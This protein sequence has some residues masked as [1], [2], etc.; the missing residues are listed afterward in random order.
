M[1]G[2]VRQ[3]GKNILASWASLAVRV[4]LVFLV[5]PFIIHTL[6]N[7][8]YGVWVLVVSIINYM[9][10]LDLGL[11]Q[12]LIRFISKFLGLGDY[13]KINSILNTAFIVYSMVGFIVIA[14][15]FILSFFAL[16]WFNIPEEHLSQGRTVLIIV[17]INTALNFILLCWGNS[18]GGFHRFD[19][20][21]AALIFEDIFRTVAI[22][23]LLKKGFGLVAFALA[24]L[25]FSQLRLVIGGGFLKVLFPRV[26]LDFRAVR[27]ET[28][29][30]LFEYGLISFLISIA[31]LLIANT[32]NVIIG[33]FLD[34]S[35]VTKFAIAAGFIV[36]L[37]SLVHA[38]SFPLRPVVS[39]YETLDKKENIIFIYTR[40]TKFLYF[41]TFAVAGIT[42][43]FADNFIY[44]WLG[45]GYSE[46]AAVLRILILPA[47]VFLPQ[48]IA[49]S[50]FYG[51]ERHKFLLYIII[52][53]GL[54]NLVLSVI[55]VRIFGIYGVAYGTAIPQVLIYLF[56]VPMIIRSMLGISLF[57]F[58]LAS[59]RSALTAFCVSAG[60]SYAL[61][62]LFFP[63]SWVIFFGEILLT[64]GL[65]ILVGYLILG[66]EEIRDIT[67]RLWY[68]T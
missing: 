29:R 31:W 32:D 14:T 39:H 6:G 17:G 33:Y 62:S 40:G 24:F 49:N 38:V 50:V 44:L 8:R 68:K 59:G 13:D 25:V 12:A 37:R 30:M 5:N 56:V 54:V 61:K 21:N 67:V 51:V 47:A 58:Y 3:L 9:T 36:Y 60:F 42:I 64:G 4:V 18:L 23:I 48:T 28:F 7:D 66:K 10:I 53:E 34:T 1:P 11:K 65:L 15:T 43:V 52:A 20:V 46:T 19:I 55:L 41:L 26:R 45:E 2:V 35:S 63:D 27:K 22:I 57:D 16:D